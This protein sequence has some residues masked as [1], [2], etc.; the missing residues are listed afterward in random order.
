MK[1]IVKRIMIRINEKLIMNEF[2]DRKSY[3]LD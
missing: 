3:L 2:G 1:Q